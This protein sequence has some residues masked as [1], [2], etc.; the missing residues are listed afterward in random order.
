MEDPKVR[1]IRTSGVQDNE[2]CLYRP[3]T[4]AM[5][6]ISLRNDLEFKAALILS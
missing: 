5:G 4:L 1:N 3:G 2:T 6:L